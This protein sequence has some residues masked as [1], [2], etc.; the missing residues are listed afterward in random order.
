MGNLL[1]LL[2]ANSLETEPPYAGQAPV[3]FSL[4]VSPDIKKYQGMGS[5][6]PWQESRTAYFPATRL[7]P[8]VARQLGS[9][10]AACTSVLSG[11]SWSPGQ[12]SDPA[13]QSPQLVRQQD[14]CN[15]N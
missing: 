2:V 5:V 12:G 15:D 4:H 8:L 14:S 6:L 3:T 1:C 9:E 10:G 13:L 11:E 7:S